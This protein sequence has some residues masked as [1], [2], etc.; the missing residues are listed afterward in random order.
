MTIA[1]LIS[2]SQKNLKLSGLEENVAFKILYAVDKRITDLM[3]FNDHKDEK[4]SSFKQILYLTYLK[5]YMIDKKPLP[6]I[7]HETFFFNHSYT[8]LDKVHIPKVESE[9]MIETA[10]EIV[11]DKKDLEVLD[12]CCGTGILGISLAQ[13]IPIHLTLS[14]ISKKAIKNTTINCANNH[15]DAT[16][17]KSDLFTKID[18]QFDVIL[19]N[20]PYI[21]FDDKDIEDSVKKYEPH[22]ALFASDNGLAFYKQIMQEVNQYIKPD[23]ILLFEIGYTQAKDVLE[24]VK[25]NPQVKRCEVKQDVFK[26]DRIIVVYF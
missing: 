4:I 11:K 21:A 12:L 3:S 15:I 24:I 7:T 22:L 1:E 8:V 20:P 19:C 5:Q 10:L 17:I 13:E 25:S 16:I 2:E 23:G 6:Y 9:T 18:K 14:D 26:H